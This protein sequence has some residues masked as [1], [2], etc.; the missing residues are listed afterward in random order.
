[1]RGKLRSELHFS[2]TIY[3][4]QCNFCCCCCRTPALFKF[5]L[6][7]SLKEIFKVSSPPLAA[8]QTPKTS[9]VSHKV[10]FS[11]NA[12]IDDKSDA[13]NKSGKNKCENDIEHKADSTPKSASSHV[14]FSGHSSDTFKY[15]PSNGLFVFGLA[16]DTKSAKKTTPVGKKKNKKPWVDEMSPLSLSFTLSLQ[17]HFHDNFIYHF[18]SISPN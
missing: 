10:D 9:H 8:D 13:N 4:W 12:D 14:K 17:F 6:N 18:F 11:K 3:W 1:M 7:D 15:Q 2:R 16:D 5:K